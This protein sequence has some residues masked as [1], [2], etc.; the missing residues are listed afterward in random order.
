ML[1][2]MGERRRMLDI[3][4]DDGVRLLLFYHIL[5]QRP[6]IVWLGVRCACCLLTIDLDK[7]RFAFCIASLFGLLPPFLP[8]FLAVSLKG[9]L[10]NTLSKDS[11]RLAGVV[12]KRFGPR[13]GEEYVR[14]RFRWL[15]S[16]LSFQICRYLIP[17]LQRCLSL[18]YKIRR[19]H[20][21]GPRS[22]R[23]SLS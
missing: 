15:S 16:H 17:N 14:A 6:G 1:T 2:H 23:A 8:R 4:D 19:T 18:N 7:R 3:F 5:L 21:V 22:P 13:R 20:L 10:A 12:Q 9:S 11:G